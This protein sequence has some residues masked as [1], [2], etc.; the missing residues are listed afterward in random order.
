MAEAAAQ[1]AATTTQNAPASALQVVLQI[2]AT[3]K[4]KNRVFSSFYLFLPCIYSLE[5][6]KAQKE[7][8]ILPANLAVNEKIRQL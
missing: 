7:A 3:A 8:D 1:N 6:Y 5:I 2:K 4:P